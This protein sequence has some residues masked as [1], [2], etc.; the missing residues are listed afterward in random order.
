MP[1]SLSSRTYLDARKVAQCGPDSHLCGSICVSKKK[2]CRSGGLA[3]PTETTFSKGRKALQSANDKIRLLPKERAIAI[4]PSTGK[5]L[6]TA[7]GNETSV[8]IPG[9][10]YPKLKGSYL[11]HNH[12]NLN[13]S[14][15]DPRSKGYSFSNTDFAIAATTE[16]AEIHAVSSGFSHTLGPPKEGWNKSWLEK[17]GWPVY[18]KHYRQTFTELV[19]KVAWGRM[20]A[21]LADRELWHI[22]IER[23]AKE[24]GMKYSRTEVRRDSMAS[25]NT[26]Y[27]Q[28]FN[29][30]LDLASAG[31]PKSYLRGF[32]A[33]RGD[34]KCGASGIP[35]NA[36]CKVGTNGETVS[37]EEEKKLRRKKMLG[38]AIGAGIG[39]L[40]AYQVH[41][42]VQKAR[43]AQA[44]QQRRATG[45]PKDPSTPWH[46]TLGVN[47][48]ATP[49]E[50]KQAYKKKAR[51]FHP[52][53]NNSKEATAKFQEI[54]A[55]HEFAQY[56]KKFGKFKKDSLTFQELQRAYAE[57]QYRRP[58]VPRDFW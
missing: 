1:A 44:E 3:N 42:E 23:S 50:I 14:E 13:W 24:L 41:K 30:P 38:R 17:K 47:K 8:A 49:E 55:A 6:F 28:G 54:N 43:Q 57:A 53:I 4:D 34:K 10:A 46:K 32:S 18:Q 48:N 21:R 12:P 2:K 20:D 26:A 9:S 27:Y 52:D 51:E 58:M 7:D 36:V 16:V 31:L 37:P 56:K 15:D 40:Y 11:T 19:S 45:A 29:T 33:I 39:G 35:D 25:K 5:S 22:T